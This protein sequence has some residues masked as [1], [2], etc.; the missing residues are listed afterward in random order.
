MNMKKD[1]E[2]STGKSEQQMFQ[3]RKR[4]MLLFL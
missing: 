3:T 1:E 4:F 2:E